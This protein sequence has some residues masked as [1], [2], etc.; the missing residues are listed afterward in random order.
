MIFPETYNILR[1]QVL[2][3]KTD[4][5]TIGKIKQSFMKDT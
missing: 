3:P 4:K 5:N 2:I 1:L